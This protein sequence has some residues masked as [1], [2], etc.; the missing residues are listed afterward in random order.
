MKRRKTNW[1]GHI[2]RRNCLLKHVIAGKIEGTGR[3]GRSSKQLLYDLNEKRRYWKLKEE[4]L[5]R[6]LRRTDSVRNSGPEVT[7]CKMNE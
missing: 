2:L 4:A 3:W 5:A 1:I 7:D 6:T